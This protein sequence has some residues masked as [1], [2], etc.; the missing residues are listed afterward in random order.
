MTDSHLDALLP[1]AMAEKAEAIGENK[2]KLPILPMFML[3]V[4]AGAFIALG[5]VF[6]T[7]VWTGTGEIPWGWSRLLGGVSFSLGLILVIV[8]GAE[9]FTGNNLIVMAWAAGRIRFSAL[10]RN[11][12]IVYAGNLIGAVG[13][14][15]LVYFAGTHDLMGGGV[16]HKA[17]AIARAKVEYGFVQ[18]VAL[19]ILCN[20][21]VC[22]AV[23]LTLSARSTVDRIAAILFPITAFVACGFEHSIANMYFIPM[24]LLLQSGWPEL[25]QPE[26]VSNLTLQSFL[27]KN[28]L[29]VTIGNIIG[30]TVLVGGV[31]WAIY[32]RKSEE[33]K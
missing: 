32:L 18:A 17:L 23:W 19:G 12:V 27:V 10:L 3:S 30:G 5:A 8:G 15:I 20:C 24:G 6:A 22:L 7:V 13:T 16:G 14:V 11:W 33:E 1:P 25:V 21:L 29:P 28:L 26:V 9:L 2:S 31:Y 4:L